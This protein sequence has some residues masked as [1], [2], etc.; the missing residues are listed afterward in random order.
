VL[1]R[2]VALGVDEFRE[3][4]VRDRRTVDPE[5]R[6]LRVVRLE[7][8]VVRPR[9]VH[10]ADREGAACDEEFVGPTWRTIGRG[11]G[12]DD[13]VL[14]AGTTLQRL[15]HR[16]LRLQL[17]LEDEAEHEAVPDEH[18]GRLEVDALEH[19]ERALADV[20]GVRAHGR[21]LQ[22]RKPR[23]VRALAPEGVVHVVVRVGIGRASPTVR[24]IHSSSNRA[25]CA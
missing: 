19:G 20:G 2:A 24:R 5:R 9:L 3:L 13:S 14:G 6:K 1:G 12:L 18:V 10:R 23:A 21:R 22:R 11:R 16:L 15:E 25:T 7:L 17:V 8:V 4:A